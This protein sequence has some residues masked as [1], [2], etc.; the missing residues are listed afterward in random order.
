MDHYSQGAITPGVR[1]LE[2]ADTG[3][4]ILDGLNEADRVTVT[5]L[6]PPVPRWGLAALR[7]DLGRLA[8]IAEA[9]SGTEPKVKIKIKDEAERAGQLLG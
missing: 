9:G 6:V 1:P 3:L 4:W 2:L 7:A 8:G 5:G